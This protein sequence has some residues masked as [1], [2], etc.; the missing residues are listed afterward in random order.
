MS[1]TCRRPQ[2]LLQQSKSSPRQDV[3]ERIQEVSTVDW[4]VLIEGETG[5][6]KELEMGVGPR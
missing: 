6:G 5:T 2:Q 4:T 3:Y 1:I